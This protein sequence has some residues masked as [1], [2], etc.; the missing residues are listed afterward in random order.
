MDEFEVTPYS[1]T[2]KVNYKKLIEQFGLSV[3]DD[4]LIEKLDFPHKLLVMRYF[5]VHRDLDKIAEF[6]KQHGK[7]AIVSGRGASEHIHLA[8]TLLFK[9]VLD[10]QKKFNAFLFVPISEDEKYFAKQ[11]LKFEEARKYA[12]ENLLDIIAI[13]LEPKDTEVLIDTLTMNAKVYGLAANIA[14]RITLSTVK[15]VYGFS[16]EMNIGLHFFPAMQSAHILYPTMEYDLPSLVIISVDQDPHMRVVRDVAEKLHVFKPAALESRFLK[17]LAGEEKMS[18][19]DPYSAIYVNDSPGLIKRKVW[20]AFTGGQPTVEEQRKYGGNPDIC[21]IYE[22]NA[23]FFDTL[24]EA[25]KR[26]ERCK[27]GD[28]LCGE[29]KNELISRL[30]KFLEEHRKKKEKAK[31]KLQDFVDL[32]SVEKYI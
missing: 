3:V 31:D 30:R 5:F 26:Y 6:Y 23:F 4:E 16:N 28:L 15:A 7:F 29:C 14:K 20:K 22:Y 32:K 21:P 18:A 10:V 25:K 27:S 11:D 1:V 8:H 13:G 12:V 2:G 9:F 17:G 19:S 24:D